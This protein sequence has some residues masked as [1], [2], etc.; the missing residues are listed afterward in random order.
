LKQLD[1]SLGA[2]KLVLSAADLQRIQAALPAEAVA[3][4]RYDAYQMGHLDSEK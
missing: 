3:G 1:E 2:L 4:T